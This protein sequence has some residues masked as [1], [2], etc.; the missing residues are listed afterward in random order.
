VFVDFDV[1]VRRNIQSSGRVRVGQGPA[2]VKSLRHALFGDLTDGENEK[3]RLENRPDLLNQP[4]AGP[5]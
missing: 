2:H 3:G 1:V 5:A 4:P